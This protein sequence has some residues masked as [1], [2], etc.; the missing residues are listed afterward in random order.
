MGGCKSPHPLWPI[1]GVRRGDPCTPSPGC[2]PPRRWAQRLC[3]A[4]WGDT[5]FAVS[6]G[7]GRC[8]VAV[9]RTSGPGSRG[10]LQSLTGRPELPPPRVLALR[11]IRDPATAEPLDRG[12]VVWFAGRGDVVAPCP[13]GVLVPGT[14]PLGFPGTVKPAECGWS[15][16]DAGPCAPIVYSCSTAASRGSLP[17][18]PPPQKK[19]PG[20]SEACT[21]P[22][23]GKGW[24]TPDPAGGAARGGGISRCPSKPCPRLCRSPE[25]HRGGLRRAARARRAGGGERGAAG[26][27]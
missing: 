5:I 23:E 10:A 25:F 7:H 2:L 3:T 22:R 12:L 19:T 9:I 6:S 26:V 8:G 24:G 4:A 27:G 1:W 20:G 13:V 18:P 16:V 15:W 11:R 21:L 17:N 14:V